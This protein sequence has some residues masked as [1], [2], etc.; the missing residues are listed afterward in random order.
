MDNAA[1][2]VAGALFVLAGV[3][4]VLTFLRQ[5][6]ERLARDSKRVPW[7]VLEARI[8]RERD[9][10]TATAAALRRQREGVPVAWAPAPRVPQ[11]VTDHLR[12]SAGRAREDDTV[13]IPKQ[14]RVEVTQ[15]LP[16]IGRLKV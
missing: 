15:P 9:A 7:T 14:S 10:E 13:I 1:V 11:Y 5:R 3:L 4:G 2:W 12:S 8:K 6:H 16:V